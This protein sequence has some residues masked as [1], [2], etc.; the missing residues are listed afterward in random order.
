MFFVNLSPLRSVKFQYIGT[1]NVGKYDH[2][3]IK[4]ALQGQSKSLVLKQWK[5]NSHE[6]FPMK[7]SKDS[8]LFLI[9]M[10]PKQLSLIEYLQIIG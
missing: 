5:T 7:F 10:D 1:I 6:T 3:L 4:I 8:N 2:F 9:K